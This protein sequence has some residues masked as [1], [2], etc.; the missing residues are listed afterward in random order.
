MSPGGDACAAERSQ[1]CEAE[2]LFTHECVEIRS[3]TMIVSVLA[4]FA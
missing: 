4:A 3:S 2:H 1:A